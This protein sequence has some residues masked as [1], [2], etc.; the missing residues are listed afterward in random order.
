MEHLTVDELTDF[1]SMS[2]ID[3]D[4]LALA[5]RVNTHIRTC[6]MCL[7]RVRAYQMVYDELASKTNSRQELREMLM[8][9]CEEEASDGLS[10]GASGEQERVDARGDIDKIVEA[11]LDK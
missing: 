6:Q 8:R 5:A 4:T 10:G 2:R 7:R 1:V 3:S 9:R 11:E